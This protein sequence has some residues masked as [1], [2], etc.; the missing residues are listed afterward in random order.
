M[1]PGENQWRGDSSER[2]KRNRAVQGGVM[3]CRGG[4]IEKKEGG[5]ERVGHALKNRDKDRGI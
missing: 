4:E 3:K 5:G 1:T 2:T